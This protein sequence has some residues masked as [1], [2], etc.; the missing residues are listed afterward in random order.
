MLLELESA[1]AAYGQS[2]V[3][4]NVD[5]GVTQ[6]DAVALI[7]R[8][9]V[10]KT[11]LLNTIAGVQKLTGGRLRFGGDDL[12][13]TPAHGRARAGIGFVPQGRHVFP[14]LSVMENLTVGLAALAGRKAVK[15]SGIASHI[16]DLFPKLTQIRN[17]KAGLLSGGEQQQLAIGRALAGQPRLLLLDEPTE[18]IQPNVVQQIEAALRRIRTEL[19]MTIL[20]V[21]QYLDFAWSF[22]ESYHVMQRGQIIRSGS[23][24]TESADEISHLV[25]I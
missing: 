21:E 24:Q 20:I 7:G 16:F 13:S 17:R 19:G 14:H 8:N 15:E 6:G 2:Q 1:C 5:M 9:G 11:T 22:A 12:T 4:W 23:T 10:G 25:N 3:L 18:G